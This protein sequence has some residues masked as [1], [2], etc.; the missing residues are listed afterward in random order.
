MAMVGERR[1][2]DTCVWSVCVVLSYVLVVEKDGSMSCMS[3]GIH[4]WMETSYTRTCK[5][6]DM[7]CTSPVCSLRTSIHASKPSAKIR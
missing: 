3:A 7:I 6:A 1:E 4:R 2:G 5:Q